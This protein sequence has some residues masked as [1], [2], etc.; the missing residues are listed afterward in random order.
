MK[1]KHAALLSLWTAAS[2]VA[3]PVARAAVVSQVIFSDHTYAD[4]NWTI[5]NK[6]GLVSAGQVATGGNPGSYRQVALGVGQNVPFVGQLN[7]TFV[8]NPTA[9]GAITGITYNMDLET[10]NA[11]GAGYFALLSQNGNFYIDN[12]H[13][14]N[15]SPNTWTNENL[16]LNLSD[17]GQLHITAQNA[18]VIDHTSL[19][20]F[21]AIGSPITFG[22]EVA[23]GG[24]GFFTSITGIDNDPIILTVTPPV[25][26][27]VPELSTWAM[28]ITG[29]MLVG[30]RLRRQA[31]ASR[32]RPPVNS[33]A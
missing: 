13:G 21:S 12:V 20:D 33:E 14:G 8:Y 16:V 2:I 3:A 25:T 32:R 1:A 29:F 7:N 31:E 10:L 26:N 4:A 9:Q 5:V 23:A 30:M 17:F 15:A 11:A 22:Y 24:A 28:M 6:F 19:P 27:G 18:L